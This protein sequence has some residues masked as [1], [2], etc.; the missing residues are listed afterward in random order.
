MTNRQTTAQHELPRSLRPF[1]SAHA[2]LEA[3]LRVAERAGRTAWCET[4]R[5]LHEM[6]LAHAA[7][8]VMLIDFAA[9]AP[10]EYLT[11]YLVGILSFREQPSAF[12][13][14]SAEG[15]LISI[16]VESK[17]AIRGCRLASAFMI[18]TAPNDC[19]D[20]TGEELPW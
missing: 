18:G 17:A 9:A 10:S 13:G 7:P 4:F 2:E 6:S 19:F 5:D 11:G 12:A 14:E 3:E 15:L 20:G 16:A 1:S 8:L